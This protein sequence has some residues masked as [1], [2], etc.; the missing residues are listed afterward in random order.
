MKPLFYLLIFIVILPIAFS[1]QKH[2][3]YQPSPTVITPPPV[4]PFKWKAY[5]EKMGGRHTWW[6]TESDVGIPPRHY[7][8]IKDVRDTLYNISETFQ[9]TITNDSTFT[10]DSFRI[11]DYDTLYG[12]SE[13]IPNAMFKFD[14]FSESTQ[15]ILFTYGANTVYGGE[16]IYL[17]YY[18]KNDSVSLLYRDWGGVGQIITTL[19]NK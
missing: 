8:P 6:G 5:V 1:C 12:G 18:I 10:I 2:P 17:Y 11:Y 7:D 16:Y 13:I 19:S 15:S 9:I 4:A 3:D 14:G